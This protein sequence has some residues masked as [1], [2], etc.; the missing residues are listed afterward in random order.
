MVE[1]DQVAVA[2]PPAKLVE[3][4]AQPTPRRQPPYHVV[5]FDDDDHTYQYVIEML[6]KLFGHNKSEA[7]L[8]AREVDTTGR[9]IVDTTTKERA[10]LKR[11]QIHAYGPD[12]R[13]KRSKGS[14]RATIEPAPDEG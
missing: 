3:E 1:S 4:P 5:L 12:F 6:G 13:L 7:Y 2:T 11:D 14:M 8:M 9:V 10:E